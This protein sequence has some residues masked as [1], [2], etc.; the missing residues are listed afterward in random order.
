MFES[1]GRTVFKNRE[2]LSFDF[3]PPKLVHR[4]AQLKRLTS[5]F[6]PV[7]ESNV[8]QMAFLTGRVGTGKTVTAKRFCMDLK[9]Y[10]AKSNKAID[11]VVVNCR[12][13][14]SEAA[15]ML[16]IVNHFQPNF[17]DRGFSISEMM[18]I[19]RKDLD[20]RN[21]HL[22]IIL[23][24]ADT[25]L[26][27]SGSDII[28]RLSRF[29]E[30]GVDSRQHVSLM[31]ISQ[32][33]IFEMLDPASAST[34]KRSNAIVF[35]KYSIGELEDIVRQRVDTALHKGAIDDDSIRLIAEASSEFGD[36]RFAI[37][38]LDKAGMLAD[39]ESSVTINP[40]HVRGAKAEAKSTITES[41]LVSLEPHQKL[42]LL[43]ICRSL[44]GKAFTTTGE[45]EEAYKIACEEFGEKP[46]A[47]TAFWGYIKDLDDSGII[48]AH[49]SG[50]GVP[51][52]TQ[53]ITVPDMPVKVLEEKL[54]QLIGDEEI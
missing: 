6:A 32:K 15:A 49:I 36:A 34:F 27:K 37:E 18:E 14:S 2:A 45:V 19:L 3:V 42:T 54:I 23:D 33:N 35:D 44:R 21:T 31:L 26:R 30:E 25:L 7:A 8:S 4:E 28:Y 50:E 43:G 20:K 17:P 53:V 29:A 41:D 51:G 9:E 10:G 5:L 11:F 12:K 1:R 13:R 52:K 40:E 38:V 48:S 39:E 22:I 47:H 46:R 16:H 24:E